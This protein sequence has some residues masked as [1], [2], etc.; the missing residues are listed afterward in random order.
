MEAVTV[1]QVMHTASQIIDAE[2]KIQELRSACMFGNAL[3]YKAIGEKMMAAGKSRLVV[4]NIEFQMDEYGFF[5][6]NRVEKKRMAA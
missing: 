6:F 4:D 2:E 1:N 5:S 3:V